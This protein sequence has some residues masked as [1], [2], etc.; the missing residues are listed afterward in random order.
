MSIIENTKPS[1]EAAKRILLVE[2][3]PIVQKVHLMILNKLG[4]NV[5][6]A[7]NAT[8]AIDKANN[9]YDLI[10]M[11]IGLPDKSGIEVTQT[12]RN[13]ASTQNIPIIVLTGYSQ[14]EI[15]NQC[16]QAGASAVFTK[17]INLEKIKHILL[18]YI[19]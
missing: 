3:E 10:F 18:E 17:P 4:C 5:D 15:E 19:K 7:V 16:L 9:P 13:D 2:D 8:E 6:L 11:D 12:L 1:F 14:T